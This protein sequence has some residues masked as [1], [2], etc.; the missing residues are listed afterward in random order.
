M[1][2]SGLLSAVESIQVRSL[3]PQVP[4]LLLLAGQTPALTALAAAQPQI[5][6][7]LVNSLA[8]SPLFGGGII[9]HLVQLATNP[10]FANLI[11]LATPP[12]FSNIVALTSGVAF[13]NLS[14]LG[15]L[16][17]VLNLVAL[18]KLSSV[19]NLVTLAGLP[20]VGNLVTVA[21]APSTTVTNVLTLGTGT[22]FTNL[23]TLGSLSSVASLVT[24]AGFSSTAMS[25]LSI[26]ANFT[27]ST[28]ANSGPAYNLT[29]FFT[30]NAYPTLPAGGGFPNI[31]AWFVAL[32]SALSI[33]NLAL[34]T[35]STQP[36]ATSSGFNSSLLFIPGLGRTGLDMTTTLGSFSSLS[37]QGGVADILGTL[38]LLGA[39]EETVA[40]LGSPT[41][42]L[43][44]TSIGA[45]NSLLHD[46]WQFAQRLENV[47]VIG[48]SS[49]PEFPTSPLAGTLGFLQAVEVITRQLFFQTGYT[50]ASSGTVLDAAMTFFT[51]GPN[52]F[53]STSSR[54]TGQFPIQQGVATDMIDTLQS[55]TD[56]AN[57]GMGV[58]H[59][60]NNAAGP[61]HDE[62]ASWNG[63]AP[64]SSALSGHK[65]GFAFGTFF[66]NTGGPFGGTGFFTVGVQSWSFFIYGDQV[67]GV[68]GPD[69]SGNMT[70]TG[71]SGATYTVSTGATPTGSPSP[72]NVFG[73]AANMAWGNMVAMLRA[74]HQATDFLIS[75]F[76]AQSNT[77]AL[78]S[79]SGDIFRARV[80]AYLHRVAFDNFVDTMATEVGNL[81]N[82][83]NLGIK[84]RFFNDGVLPGLNSVR[85]LAPAGLPNRSLGTLS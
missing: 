75:G 76:E 68:S 54:P 31:T 6:S 19:T 16:P 28:F 74:F 43:R 52:V 85:N 30:S 9:A 38:P 45:D 56:W 26:I 65:G 36:A 22:V 47:N 8:L 5:Q 11:T 14:A 18:A 2:I 50:I 71:T 82:G 79:P 49:L 44:I 51:G 46:L 80:E 67:A 69:G 57:N 58:Q 32:Q 55:M 12:T 59:F 40:T 73:G 3:L 13:V 27:T 41:G 29:S 10:V 53:G 84:T 15:A 39:I 62:E 20:S 34:S 72:Q 64:G 35:F 83:R 37:F 48:L 70:V 1:A 66:A 7:L 81:F 33:S 63:S 77:G 21:G 25:N 42:S 4:N 24:L 78:G 17:S 61:F 60:L 23:S